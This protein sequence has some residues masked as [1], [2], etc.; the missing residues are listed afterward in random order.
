[1]ST[2]PSPARP[3]PVRFQAWL[4]SFTHQWSLEP[5]GKHGPL[6]VTCFPS[7]ASL[8]FTSITCEELPPCPINDE[9]VPRL[10]PACL[11]AICAA[12]WT[13]IARDRNVPPAERP[14]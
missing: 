14:S 4:D 10:C 7:G 6:E 8:I 1:M 2:S 11:A 3:S 9:G 13:V 5:F 12:G